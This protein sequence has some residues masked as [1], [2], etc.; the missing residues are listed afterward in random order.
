MHRYSHQRTFVWRRASMP[1][2][3][4]FD[5]SFNRGGEREYTY[6]INK[7]KKQ[8]KDFVGYTE[9]KRAVVQKGN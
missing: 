3:R 7:K 5:V 6:K 1:Y 9:K 8:V 4:R 2:S